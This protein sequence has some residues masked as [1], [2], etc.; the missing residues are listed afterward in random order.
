MNIN[1][2][3]IGELKQLK[4]L[5]NL[6]ESKDEGV[7]PHPYKIGKNYLIVTVTRIYVG[8]LVEVYKNELVLED[9]SWVADTGRFSAAL[10]NGI[11]T[12]TSSEIEL[13]NTPVIIGRGSL[14][15]ACE[16]MHDLPTKTK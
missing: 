2:L 14:V 8:R 4:S 6:H 11:E 12:Q 1:E 3:T 9:A 7:D 10:K 16:Y 5:F 15:D 13:F